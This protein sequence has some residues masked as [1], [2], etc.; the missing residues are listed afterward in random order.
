MKNPN[1]ATRSI[2]PMGRTPVISGRVH[3]SLHRR[4]AAAAKVNGRTMSEELAAL[5]TEALEYRD[6]YG[7][8][9]TRRAVEWLALSFV[10][11]GE[12]AA[13]EKGLSPSGWTNDADARRAAAMRL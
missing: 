7:S 1:T 8:A 9:E 3:E 13:K 12:H 2:R 11:A 5:A 4:I 10:M 6:K